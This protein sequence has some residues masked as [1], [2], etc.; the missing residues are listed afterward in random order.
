M[1][2]LKSKLKELYVFEGLGKA[3]VEEVSAGELCVLVGL[4]GFELEIL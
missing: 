4:E 3:K 1:E 2:Q